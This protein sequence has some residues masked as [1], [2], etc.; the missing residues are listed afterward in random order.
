MSDNTR[1]TYD[2]SFKLKVAL[3]AISND[4][5]VGELCKKFDVA[6]NQIYTWKK[7]LEEHGHE[8]FIDKRNAEKTDDYARMLCLEL[9]KVKEE[10][11]FL[12]LVLKK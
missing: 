1:K 8:I 12:A 3:A 5:N 2:G 9:E 4:G 7:Q 11:D 6:V 10:R